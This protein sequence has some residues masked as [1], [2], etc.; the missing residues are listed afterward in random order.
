MSVLVCRQPTALF[1]FIQAD[2][3]SLLG[4]SSKHCFA[5]KDRR[6]SSLQAHLLPPRLAVKLASL[7]PS[8]LCCLPASYTR[9]RERDHHQ[10]TP[11]FFTA[12]HRLCSR[13]HH[14]PC[15]AKVSL[16]QPTQPGIFLA[17]TPRL[18]RFDLA[19]P[20][21]VSLQS[22]TL[23][24]HQ[25]QRLRQ[26]HQNDIFQHLACGRPIHLATSSPNK[27]AADS[28]SDLALATSFTFSD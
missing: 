14:H 25:R 1:S 15:A 26:H 24:Q 27:R 16:A 10:D 20:A 13:T 7:L 6:T 21:T 18:P 9:D 4:L 28:I 5:A 12:R 17:L 11:A 22:V 3:C 23:R 2:F 19:A 8:L